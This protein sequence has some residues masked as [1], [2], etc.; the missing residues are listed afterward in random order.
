MLGSQD[1]AIKRMCLHW[2][3]YFSEDILVASKKI[4][5]DRS[6]VKTYNSKCNLIQWAGKTYDTTL[7]EKD[8]NAINS[9]DDLDD[10]KEK[11]EVNVTKNSVKIWGF[12]FSPEDYEFMNN[13]FSEW[14]SKCVIESKPKETLVREL[15]VL[16]LQ[17]NKALLEGKVDLYTKL[18]ESYQKTLDRASLTPKIEEA[19]DKAGELPMG[20]MI[21]R[22][23]NDRPIPEPYDEWKDVDGIIKM[24]TIYFLGHLCK[25]LGLKNRYSKMYEDEMAKYRV[26]IPEL[27]EADDEDIF[28][29]L[30]NGGGDR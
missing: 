18:T 4:S 27:E 5:A 30:S 3:M 22:Y 17:Q 29:F 26:E 7:K 8:G 21:D 6:R 9:L 28:E 10:I 19:S 24:F 14:K 1:E 11:S 16:K 15:C 25:M 20:M 13:Q 12:G 2:D 23:E